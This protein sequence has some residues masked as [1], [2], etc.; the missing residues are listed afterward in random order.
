MRRL[1][2]L[3][4]ILLASCGIH[5]QETF[6]VIDDTE[7]AEEINLPLVGDEVSF[8]P[9]TGRPQLRERPELPPPRFP[10]NE[11]G[12]IMILV[13]HGLHPTN[14]GPFD[15]L[16]DDFRN[17]L[18]TLYDQGYRLISMED[19][20]NNNITTPAGYTPVVLT[21]DDGLPSAFSL[22]YAEDGT[23][24]PVPGTA[25]YI[26]NEFY[27]KNPDFG[28]T[29]IFFVNGSPQPFSGAGTLAERFAFLLEHGYELGNHSYSHANFAHLNARRIQQEIGRVDRMLRENAPG[30][31][32][33]VFA[34]PFGIRPRRNLRRYIM[35]GEYDGWEYSHAWALRVGNT[36][37]PAVPYHVNFDP[38]NVARVVPTDQST[39]HYNVVDLGFLLRR[40]ER[41]P[42]LRFISDGDPNVVTVPSDR[43]QYVDRDALAEFNLEL[44]VYYIDDEIFVAG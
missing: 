7:Y 8:V 23:L 4:V 43:L 15:C 3:A 44:V 37:V 36:F 39:A 19:L 21:F 6:S 18:Q 41:Y 29:A 11:I 24:V 40:F 5:A 26:L 33:L 27:E 1:A 38:Q 35:A 9:E 17:N 42:H 20:I 14:P 31:Q 16:T 32:P 28:R 30:Y 12:E 10:P 34:Y 13:F 2:L 22:E 25:V